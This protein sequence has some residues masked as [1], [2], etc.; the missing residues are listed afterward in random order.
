MIELTTELVKDTLTEIVEEFGA[1]HVYVPEHGMGQDCAYVHLN[2]SDIPEDYTVGCLIGHFY[3]K[4][5][6]L[7]IEEVGEDNKINTSS[8]ARQLTNLYERRKSISITGEDGKKAARMLY[9]AQ[10]S[11]DRGHEWGRALRYAIDSA[12]DETVDKD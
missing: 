12:S 2:G 7:D 8:D 3:N 11:Q 5:G 10:Y 9:L 6:I 4:L 1:D